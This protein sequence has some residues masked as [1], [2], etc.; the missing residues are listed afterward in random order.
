M[1]DHLHK[2]YRSRDGKVLGVC[3][4]IA[5]YFGLDVGITRLV[6]LLLIFFTGLWPGLVLYFIAGW[7]M[8]LEPYSDSYARHSSEYQRASC[9]RKEKSHSYKHA[10]FSREYTAYRSPDPDKERMSSL[11]NRAEALASRIQ[12]LEGT[13]TKNNPSW[14]ERLYKNP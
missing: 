10:D 3:A 5:K 2:I 7:I 14:E 6:T 11:L 8:P 13:V 1:Q 9:G 4:G 12:D